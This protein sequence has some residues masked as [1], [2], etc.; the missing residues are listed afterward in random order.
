M[1]NVK[2]IGLTQNEIEKISDYN[3]RH[4]IFEIRDFENPNIE[5]HP[6]DA[7]IDRIINEINRLPVNS[8]ILLSGN[9]HYLLKN[10][11]NDWSAYCIANDY[12]NT[13]LKIKENI[14][15]HRIA[16]IIIDETLTGNEL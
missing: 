7:A 4:D 8:K 3:S 16:I 11:N 12:L 6:I 9:T 15:N 5:P 10:N 13:D 14:D 1:I 2:N